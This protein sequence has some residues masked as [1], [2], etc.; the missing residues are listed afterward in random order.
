MDW[1][2]PW[3]RVRDAPGRPRPGLAQGGSDG[4]EDDNQ[5]HGAQEWDRAAAPGLCDHPTTLVLGQEVHLDLGFAALLA[6]LLAAL[7][8]T[9]RLITRPMQVR[10]GPYRMSAST[11]GGRG[12]GS[13]GWPVRC[14]SRPVRSAGRSCSERTRIGESGPKPLAPDRRWKASTGLS[15]FDRP[16]P[17]S[18]PESTL[19]LC[20]ARGMRSSIRIAS[21]GSADMSSRM[22][23]LTGMARATHRDFKS[24]ATGS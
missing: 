8:Q 2:T 12:R 14:S 10:K 20:A 1:P 11:R 22:Q 19:K 13:T 7:L 16:S 21:Q 3:A 4:L 17:R 9:C 23:E 5:Q 24:T 18:P 15:P 6:V